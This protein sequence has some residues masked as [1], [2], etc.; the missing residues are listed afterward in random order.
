VSSFSNPVQG[1]GSGFYDRPPTL[2]PVLEKTR[3]AFLQP[4]MVQ[5]IHADPCVG[6]YFREDVVVTTDRRGRV[7]VWKR[8]S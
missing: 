4:V 3:V 6:L 1:L 8:P 7:A 2:H 5:T